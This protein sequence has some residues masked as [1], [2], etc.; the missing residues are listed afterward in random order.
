MDYDLLKKYWLYFCIGVGVLM[1]AVLVPATLEREVRHKQEVYQR[2][3]VEKWYKEQPR[4][5]R[6]SLPYPR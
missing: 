2:D 5:G 4:T 3:Q 6:A 1:Y